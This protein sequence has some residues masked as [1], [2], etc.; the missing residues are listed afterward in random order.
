MKKQLLILS[1]AMGVA[2]MVNEMSAH[3]IKVR[4]ESDSEIEVLIKDSND[5]RVNKVP[6]VIEQDSSKHFKTRGYE[7][8][9]SIY[10]K[11]VRFGA[12]AVA[13]AIVTLGAKRR[14]ATSDEMSIRDIP[15]G[16]TVTIYGLDDFEIKPIKHHKHHKQMKKE[17]TQRKAKHKK[18]PKKY[19]KV[20]HIEKRPGY[21]KKEYTEEGPGYQKQEMQTEED[22]N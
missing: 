9:Y 14:E 7:E 19:K 6:D 15:A 10:Y 4:N 3:G 11:T 17:G 21:M 22:Y 1:I 8:P 2:F 12:G 16:S 13:K 5:D 20:K 18:Q